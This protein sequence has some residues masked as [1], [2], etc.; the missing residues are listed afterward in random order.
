MLVFPREEK[1]IHVVY[2]MKSFTYLLIGLP[3]YPAGNLSP[4]LGVKHSRRPVSL[5]AM[6]VSMSYRQEPSWH[7][8]SYI[9]WLLLCCSV[10]LLWLWPLILFI[11]YDIYNIQY[12]HYLAAL[13]F[14][15]CPPSIAQTISGEYV[16]SYQVLWLTTLN[17]FPLLLG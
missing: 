10:M 16:W 9:H 15:E 13:F 14:S 1:I 2:L 12:Y 3:V 6:E 11:F 7:T 17:V 5:T 4:V 8:A